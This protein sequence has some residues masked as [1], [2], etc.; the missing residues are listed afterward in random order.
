M[1][2]VFFY[3][4]R[5]YSGNSA[6]LNKAKIRWKGIFFR[7]LC[8]FLIYRKFHYDSVY[9]LTLTLLLCEQMHAM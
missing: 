2:Q 4:A 9:I 5:M 3:Y 6:R 7:C 1:S 8:C